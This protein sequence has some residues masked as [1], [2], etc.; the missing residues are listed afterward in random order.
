M[1]SDS[2]MLELDLLVLDKRLVLEFFLFHEICLFFLHLFLEAFL[3]I[4]VAL[5]QLIPSILILLS[6]YFFKLSHLLLNFV[7][8]IFFNSLPFLSLQ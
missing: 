5:L 7:F 2:I 3:L 6:E 8:S 4:Y 1:G